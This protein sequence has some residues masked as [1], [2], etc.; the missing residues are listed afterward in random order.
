M[1]FGWNPREVGQLRVS[2][3]WMYLEQLD[4]LAKKESGEDKKMQIIN[5]PKYE[6]K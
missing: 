5:D 6:G 2:E 3:F 4:D 1:R